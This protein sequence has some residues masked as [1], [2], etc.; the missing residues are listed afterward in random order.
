MRA[1][2]GD[3]LRWMRRN[4]PIRTRIPSICNCHISHTVRNISP[5]IGGYH[6][7]AI[8]HF[9][10]SGNISLKK[11]E[12]SHR[13]APA[14]VMKFTYLRSI[15]LSISEESYIACIILEV[16]TNWS[17]WDGS[18]SPVRMHFKK[19]SISHWNIG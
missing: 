17:M 5:A 16:M 6:R 4:L 3:R 1:G 2:K 8:S 12:P 15:S 13:T 18:F 11:Q 9:R 7:A 14:V 19:E 10:D